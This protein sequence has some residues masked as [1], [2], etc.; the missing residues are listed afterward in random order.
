MRATSS[1]PGATSPRRSW[2]TGSGSPLCAAAMP[3]TAKPIRTLED[4]I[5]W[6]KGG[7]L[8]GEAW[9]R[10]GFL[11]DLLEEDVKNGLT[12]MGKPGVFPWSRVSGATDGDVRYIY[13][14]EHQPVDLVDRPAAWTTATTRSTSSTPGTMTVT[15]GERMP[16]PQYASDTARQRDPRPQAGCRLRRRAARQALPGDSCA[17]EIPSRLNEAKNVVCPDPRCAKGLW[18]DRRS[19][20]ASASTSRMANSSFWSVRRAAESRPCCA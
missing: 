20:M 10:I 6:A 16:T 14:G 3:A 17:S 5:W 15:P 2:S 8:H 18:R 9:K 12:P 1:S 11:R 13:L 19:C 4:L 7:E